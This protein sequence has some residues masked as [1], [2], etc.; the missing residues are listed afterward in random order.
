MSKCVGPLQS[1]TRLLA[2]YAWRFKQLTKSVVYA[3]QGIAH[4]FINHAAGC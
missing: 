2:L 3:Q 1:C 4:V